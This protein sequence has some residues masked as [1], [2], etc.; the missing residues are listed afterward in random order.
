MHDLIIQV[1]TLEKKLLSVR[2][3]KPKITL[4]VRSD[5]GDFF[6]GL[7]CMDHL[8][9]LKIKLVTVAD[10]FCA[11]AATFVLMGSKNRR[12]M[13]HAHLLIHQLSTGAMGKYEELKDEIKNCDK[14]METLRKIYTQY[15]QIPEDKLNKLLKKDIY[16]TA[17]DCERWGIAKNNM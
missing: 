8:R 6:A 5:G 12:I 1:K 16:F 2:E 11:S 10:G 4:Y 3:Y 7:S 9:R 17:E 14:L 13:P 15:T